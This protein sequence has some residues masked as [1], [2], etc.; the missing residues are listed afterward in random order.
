[1]SNDMPTPTQTNA[2]RAQM[3]AR[4]VSQA[5]DGKL[6]ITV[7]NVAMF[8]P[9]PSAY[10]AEHKAMPDF[11]LDGD[12]L[13]TFLPIAPD[14]LAKLRD[15]ELVLPDAPAEVAPQVTYEQLDA[16]LLELERERVDLKFQHQTA[17]RDE[18]VTH[19]ELDQVAR[20]FLTNFAK[21]QTPSELLKDN[22]RSESERRRQIAAGEI[23]AP[24]KAVSSVGPSVLDK[25][26]AAQRGGRAGFAGR[27]YSRGAYPASQQGGM[28]KPPSER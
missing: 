8:L 17:I 27:G 12:D 16:K 4:A 1:M 15:V 26:A 9:G 24:R 10:S 5:R 6:P 7:R 13:R 22:A 28:V 2:L 14:V 25:F 19:N 23:P 3:V 20:L 11:E 21:P 18:V